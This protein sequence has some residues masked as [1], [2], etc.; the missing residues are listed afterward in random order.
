MQIL[1]TI[2]KRWKLTLGGLALVSLVAYADTISRIHTF[3]DG[4]ILTAEHL[5]T[6]FDNVVDGVNSITNDNISSSAAISP[7]KISSAIAGSGI[8]RNATTG[9]LTPTTDG[10]S[11][12]VGGSGLEVVPDD[13]TLELDSGGL[14]VKDDGIT[15]A[16][17][18]DL[19]VTTGKINDLAVTQAKRAALGQQISSSS[20]I[21]STTSLSYSDVTNLSVTITTTGRP[22]YIGLVSDGSG[23]TNGCALKAIGSGGQ[24]TADFR[25]KQDATEIAQAS[26]Q[27]TATGSATE[28]AAINV[29]PCSSLSHIYVPSAGTYVYTVQAKINSGVAPD[30]AGVSFAKLVAYEL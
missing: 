27:V 13:S 29:V 14:R 18:D 23:G 8:T 28:T 3:S 1:T 22:V 20:G 17:L 2:A 26:L 21:F 15:T 9:Q 12:T 24:G 5:N 19:A 4:D 7:A 30:A 6:E 10:T 25:I 16:K 11:I